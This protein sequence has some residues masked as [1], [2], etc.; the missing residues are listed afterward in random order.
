MQKRIIPCLI[1]CALLLASC[2]QPQ[3]SEDQP[4]PSSEDTEPT[5]SAPS[6]EDAADIETGLSE[7]DKELYQ[8]ALALQ[9][10]VDTLGFQNL[11]LIDYPVTVYL[12]GA[13]YVMQGD[14]LTKRQPPFFDHI[15]T[16]AREVEDH[17]EV[18]VP[19]YE[20]WREIVKKGANVD[21]TPSR[22]INMI[23]HEAFHAY[24]LENYVK[25]TSEQ[26]EFHHAEAE[27]TLDD[28]AYRS[29]FITEQRLLDKA[30][31][32]DGTV[33]LTELLNEWAVLIE[34][35]ND[36][37]TDAQLEAVA[38][39]ELVEGSAYYF[40][41]EIHRH[42][43]GEKK[44]R[45]EYLAPFDENHFDHTPTGR[46]YISGMKKLVLI[47]RLNP[48]WKNGLTFSESVDSMLLKAME[49]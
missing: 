26:F 47:E 20:E 33:D 42:L 8:Q 2:A 9:S 12:D 48:N 3:V 24:Q 11:R 17:Y 14:T 16:T 27:K 6:A 43:E 30:V 44:Y 5:A 28:S 45:K 15:H 10:Y 1:I 31:S 25:T 29:L 36:L 19:P 46:Y 13:D 34:Q 35:Y 23:W 32:A 37:L 22:H 39:Y 40:E 49:G 38:L 21:F 18:F 7:T 41:S 4:T